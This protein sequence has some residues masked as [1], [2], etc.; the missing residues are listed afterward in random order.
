MPSSAIP[1][2]SRLSLDEKLK[3]VAEFA[4][5][6]HYDLRLMESYRNLP[7]FTELENNLGPFK[8]ATN[9]LVNGRDYL[10]PMDTEEPSVVAAASRMAKIVRAGGGF[11]GKYLDSKMTGQIQLL[12]VSDFSGA[13]KAILGAKKDLLKS[14]NETN[15]F[16]SGHGGG[17]KEIEVRKVETDKGPHLGVYLSVDTLDAMGANV[18]NT[19]LE[20]I[21]PKIAELSGGSPNLKIVSN[22]ALKRVVSVSCK[23]PVE[24]LATGGFSGEYVAERVIM[25]AAFAKADPFRAAT[26]NK[27]AMNGIDAVLLAT[28]NDFRAVEAGVHAY[29][30]RGCKY[31]AITDYWFEGGN[32]CGKIEIPMPVGTVGGATGLKRSRLA[33]KVIGVK[34]AQELGVVIASVGLANNLAAMS[35]IVSEGIQKGHMRLHNQFVGQTK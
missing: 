33:L 19:M 21:S 25:A 14:A 27:G 11:E 24:K 28:G 23:V 26:H 5:L 3:K 29:A 18:I 12:G 8:I 30:A 4:N 20:A 34:S 1:G 22:Y 15:K 9:F 2:F 16:I 13:K 17:A 35:A 6:D 32:L 7:D 31:T 10:I